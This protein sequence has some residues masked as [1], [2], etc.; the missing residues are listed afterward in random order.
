MRGCSPLP[1]GRCGCSRR[2]T[3]SSAWGWRRAPRSRRAFPPLRRVLRGSPDLGRPRTR[4]RGSGKRPGGGTGSLTDI[5]PL[6]PGALL[7]ARNADGTPL[8]PTLTNL[9][10]DQQQQAATASTGALKQLITAGTTAAPSGPN[11]VQSFKLDLSSGVPTFV[12]STDSNAYGSLTAALDLDFS[13]SHLFDSIGHAL[14]H[15]AMKLKTAVVAWSED[16]GSWLVNLAVTIGDDVVNFANLAISDIKDAFHLIG[17]FFQALGADIKAAIAWLKHNVLELL[18][19]AGQNAAT[20]QGW[21]QQAP[22]ELTTVITGIDISAKNFF[23]SKEQQAHQLIQY[24]ETQVEDETFGSA[25]PLPPPTDDSGSAGTQNALLK[26]LGLI[27]K[28][29]NDMPGK[30]LMDKLLSYLPVT[31]TGP[32][33]SPD[34]FAPLVDD[35]TQVW[36]DVV[37]LSQSLI[38]LIEATA[39]DSLATKEQVTQM[40]MTAWFADLDQTVHDLLQLADAI[41]DLVLQLVIAGISAIGTYFSYQYQVLGRTSILGLILD[42]AGID[43]TLSL[44]HLVSLVVAY[45]ATLIGRILGHDSLFPAAT[46]AVG[47]GPQ[48]P[49]AAADSYQVGLGIC[50]AVAQGVWGMADLVGDLQSF[51]D[52]SGKRGSPSGVIDYF[53]ILCPVAETVL[54]WPSKSFPDGSTAYPFYGGIADNTTD[55]EL[56]PPTILT[57]IPVRV[58]DP[59]EDRVDHPGPWGVPQRRGGRREGLHGAG[60]ADARR[61]HQHRPGCRV[62][63]E[64]RLR[65]RGDRRRCAGQPVLRPR[66]ARHEVDERDHRGRPSPDQDDGRRRRQHRRGHLHRRVGEPPAEVNRAGAVP[67]RRP[68]RG[69]SNPDVARRDAAGP[70]GR[71]RRATPSPRTALTRTLD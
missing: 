19:E 35:L 9:P 10:S 55:W 70:A 67:S 49:G 43:P 57:A 31:D 45:P 69:L 2:A 47:D 12:T 41:A 54:L 52:A 51:G 42:E 6:T 7:S 26:D 62:Q 71:L 23:S 21:L 3:G 15:A 27:G 38:T 65:R 63:R 1:P 25:A 8:A 64:E 22:A 39:Q 59:D 13:F 32:Q 18:R 61:D 28:V 60:G 16:A 33:V 24:L 14:R 36:E 4:G 37:D 20:I 44:D 29:M 46:Q 48:A 11:A 30:W 68:A 17:G 40:E 50:G 58:R 34:T 53:D 5:G 66:A 56:L